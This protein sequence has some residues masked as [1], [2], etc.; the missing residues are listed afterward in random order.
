MN[1]EVKKYVAKCEICKESK[2]STTSTAP[3][4][5]NQRIATR[6]FQIVCMDYIQ[7]LPRSKQGN[8]HLLVVLDI[9]SKY[10]LL[11]PVKKIASSNQCTIL[12]ERWF[13]KLSVPQY[14]ITDNAT[15]CLYREFQELLKR[16][17][18]QHWA[19]ERQRSQTNPA[20]RLNRTINSMIRTYVR[21]NQ[22]VWDTKVSEIEF[23]LN[24]TVHGSTKFTPYRVIFGHEIITRG[25]YHRTEDN[26][27]L[28]EEERVDRMKGVNKKNFELVREN[29]K[30]AY[31]S[32]KQQYDL[33]LKRYS[34]TFTIGQR[35]LKRSFAFSSAG[36]GFNAKLGPQYKACAI[37][38]KKG[39]SSYEVADLNGRSLGIFSAADLK[40]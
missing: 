25:S 7:S 8:A 27:E 14:V 13:H 23:V 26:N 11:V 37:V 16:F 2:H 20:E 15:T 38:A 29:L 17:E 33:R 9:F 28:S 31:E 36:K 30:R 6:P 40:A 4:M 19:N 1:A 21:T 12:E 18:I 34:P 10:C 5:G 24:N 35:V 3:E 32:T 39:N 22:K